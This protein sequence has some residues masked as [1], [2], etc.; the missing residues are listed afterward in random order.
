MVTETMLGMEV[1]GR[2]RRGPATRRS[3]Q[4]AKPTEEVAYKSGIANQGAWPRREPSAFPD[5]N[6]IGPDGK[7]TRTLARTGARTA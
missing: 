1:G 2:Q 4:S 7:E 6:A 3:R 5:G